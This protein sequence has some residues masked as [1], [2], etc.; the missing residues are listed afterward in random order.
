MS[1]IRPPAV[2][3]LFYPDD[4]EG[5]K[6]VVSLMFE[7]VEKLL[8]KEEMPP[9]PVRA[10][11]AP[12]AGYI[13]SGMMAARAYAHLPHHAS[14]VAVLGP[15]H[16][17]GYPGI[18]L[19][20][21]DAFATP[22]G[23]VRVDTQTVARLAEM[24]GVDY[25]EAS[26]AQEHSIEVHLPFLQ[27]RYG[28]FELVPLAVGNAEITLV[29]DVIGELW[30]DPDTVIVISSDLS[31]YH[32]YFTAL[33]LDA[34]TI[35]QI[36]RLELPVQPS[37]A[38]GAYAINGMLLAA[39]QLGLEPWFSGSSNSA[40]SVGTPDRVVGYAAIAFA[41]PPPPAPVPEDAGQTLTSLARGSI[42]QVLLGAEAP[43]VPEAE[44]L[45]RPGACFVTLTK[46]GQLRGCIGSLVAYRDLLDDLRS[47]ARAAAF[48]D[49]RFEP[50]DPE[51]LAECRIEVSILSEPEPLSFTS[52]ADALG[53]LRPGVDGVILR[54]T[55]HQAT[56]LPQ[57]WEQ[58]PEPETFFAS[59]CHKAGLPPNYW[60]D[61]VEIYRY[62]VTAFEEPDA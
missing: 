16:R 41:D 59:L 36:R 62:Q 31:H 37:Q 49:P 6:M 47:N 22:L 7:E 55:G 25:F 10:V 43:Q 5:L 57:V 60:G 39:A 33:Q 15:T 12:H 38:C 26:H 44:W 17:V 50:L 13:Y 46:H 32:D 58:L 20:E 24:N 23:N 54:T 9:T 27:H 29:A 34:A 3:G 28:D 11:I 4:P 8:S 42:A 35:S 14:R 61:D 2:A 56:Y 30:K 19:S 18:A 40:D 21:A 51:E 48:R 45:E 52:K 1:Q 53:Q